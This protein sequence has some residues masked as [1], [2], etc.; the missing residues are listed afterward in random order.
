MHTKNF[1]RGV[2]MYHFGPKNQS[3]QQVD[4]MRQVVLCTKG[5]F[6]QLFSKLYRSSAYGELSPNSQLQ[7]ATNNQQQTTT[8]EF[9]QL[10]AKL[11]RP[12]RL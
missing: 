8:Y 12:S 7:R 9:S 11:W 1:A 5:D 4:P 2:G 10:K 6:S 3:N